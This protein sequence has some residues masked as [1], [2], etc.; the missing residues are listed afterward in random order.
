MPK[1]IKWFMKTKAGECK[2]G[3]ENWGEHLTRQK[4]SLRLLPGGI[5]FVGANWRVELLKHRPVAKGDSVGVVPSRKGGRFGQRAARGKS[6][7]GHREMSQRK[8]QRW[9][10]SFLGFFS[11]SG[12]WS[13]LAA[14][15]APD[16]HASYAHAASRSLP[17]LTVGRND[18]IGSQK[19]IQFLKLP[20]PT[21]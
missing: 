11:S 15:Q 20:E 13:F 17:R 6:A 3:I 5:T 14:T 9:C 7:R 1:P 4:A 8:C 19:L 12:E 21:V 18:R 10:H 16:L 2:L